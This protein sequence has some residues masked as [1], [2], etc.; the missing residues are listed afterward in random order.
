MTGQTHPQ[1]GT[2]IE[3]RGQ[4]CRHQFSPLATWVLKTELTVLRKYQVPLPAKLS[5]QL[6]FL[7]I[8]SKH[9]NKSQSF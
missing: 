5:H 4:M 9:L 7:F 6:R 1:Y 8:Y 3:I 2:R